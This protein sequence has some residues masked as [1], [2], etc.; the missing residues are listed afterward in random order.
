MFYG[1]VN[2]K[3]KIANMFSQR[4]NFD[5]D[6]KAMEEALNYLKK[7]A[8]NNNLSIAIPYGIRLWNCKWR[9]EHSL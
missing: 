4:P 9:L 2:N 1:D 3:K 8:E 6:Y 5:T 7:W